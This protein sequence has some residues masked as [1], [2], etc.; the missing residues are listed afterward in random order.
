MQ[1]V[2]LDKN[3]ADIYF[4]YARYLDKNIQK[5]SDDAW[6]Q[7]A[8]I[9]SSTCTF[10]L[11]STLRG[12]KHLHHCLPRLLSIWLDLA[13]T[14]Q[15][16]QA[17]KNKDNVL[18]AALDHASSSLAKLALTMREWVRK[19]PSYYLLTAAPQLVSRIC[20]GHA[21]TWQLLKSLLVNVLCRHPQQTFWHLVSVSKNSNPTRKARCLEIF[22]EAVKAKPELDKFL[23]DALALAKKIDELCELKTGKRETRISLKDAMKSLPALVNSASFSPLILPN[24][25]NMVV[26]LPTADVSTL[27]SLH[28]YNPFPDGTVT[29]AG[30]Q[31]EVILMQSLVQPKKI[32]F[33]GSDG[34]LHPFLAKPKDDLRR[35]CR[36][37]D[38]C[39]LLNKLF[40]E[41]A[42]SRKRDLHIRTYTVVPTNENNGLIEW[43][44]NLRGLR[45]IIIQ[46]HKEHGLNISGKWP[47]KYQSDKK[48]S[49][50][51]KKKMLD[52]CIED[53]QGAVFADWFASTFHDP[54]AWLMARMAFTRTT[55]VMSM[56]GYIIGLGDRYTTGLLLGISCSL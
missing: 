22:Q 37:M 5:F 39:F 12:P 27:A 18:C 2:N 49:L 1:A 55:A 34:R 56:V 24:Q 46:K 50:D 6:L 51:R 25:R 29:I 31:D 32:T 38:F 48:D 7:Q 16:A 54:Q 23:R 36:L 3:S 42:G 26:C 53:Q 17:R 40:R 52:K 45:P 19:A 44:N 8:E 41:D 43:V 30:I 10:Y 9:I 14:L 15:D 20:H 11:K 21:E 33:R 13:A 35:D 47:T 4:R 28:A